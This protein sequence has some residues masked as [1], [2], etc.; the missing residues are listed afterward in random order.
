MNRHAADK[1]SD[2]RS[3][4]KTVPAFTASEDAMLTRKDA[5]VTTVET[6]LLKGGARAGYFL[7]LFECVEESLLKQLNPTTRLL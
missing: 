5:A 2:I 6:R 1:K 3:W 7:A 4:E